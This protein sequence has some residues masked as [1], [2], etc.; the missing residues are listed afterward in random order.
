M[1]EIR[2]KLGLVET[3]KMYKEKL[4]GKWWLTARRNIIYVLLIV[5]IAVYQYLLLNSL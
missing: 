1:S 2:K 3:E 5:R 4:Y